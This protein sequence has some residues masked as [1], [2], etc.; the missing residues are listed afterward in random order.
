MTEEKSGGFL[1]TSDRVEL[2]ATIIMALAAIFTAWAAFQS[3][4]WSGEQATSFSK[5]GA[6]RTESTRFDTRAGQLAGIDVALFT[7]WLDALNTDANTGAI[8][9]GPG[10]LYE[11]TEGTLSGFLFER[12]RDEFRP[13]MDAWLVL[14]AEDRTTAPATPFAMPEYVL[15]RINDALNDRERSVRG[16]RILIVGVAY[17]RDVSDVRES[18]ALDIIRLLESRGARVSYHDPFVPELNLDGERLSSA[19]L[20]EGVEAADMVVIVTDHQDIDYP[21]LVAN[22]KVVFDTRNATRDIAGETVLRL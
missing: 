7:S 8:E 20:K 12:M 6:A 1:A 3:A 13:A 15:A 4:K 9:F 22:A 17:K 18:P 5:A 21:W 19:P 14:F 16:S 10:V 2:I 11:P